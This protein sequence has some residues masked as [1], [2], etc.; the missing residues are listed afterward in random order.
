MKSIF[1]YITFFILLCSSGWSYGQ[2]VSSPKG[3][4]EINYTKGCTDLP[5]EVTLTDTFP[6]HYNRGIRFFSNTQYL[7]DTTHTYTE[8]G[9]YFVAML[10]ENPT[11][12]EYYD[13]LKVE[14][15]EPEQ[16]QFFV[17]NCGNN[18]IQVKVEHQG[19]YNQ[20]LV[21]VAG[22]EMV[23]ELT[24]TENEVVTEFTLDPALSETVVKVTG[25][26]AGEG[27]AGNCESSEK[28]VQVLSNIEA[29][30]FTSLQSHIFEAA[31]SAFISFTQQENVYHILEY[32]VNGDSE[33]RLVEEMEGGQSR[34]SDFEYFDFQNNYYCFRGKAIDRCSG[35]EIVSDLICT[36]QLEVTP[37]DHRNLVKF[38]TGNTDGLERI[39]LL[40][41]GTAIDTLA[42]TASG[43]FPDSLISCSTTYAIRLE[44]EDG[45][46]SVTK[47]L[48]LSNEGQRQLPAPINVVS[49]W[50]D[51]STVQFSLPEITGQ[52]SIRLMAYRSDGT[53][54]VNEADT[55]VISLPARGENT[56]YRFR[57]VDACGN[58]SA[59]SE[60]VC[61][62]YLQ[63]T[64]PSAEEI[65]LS[66]NEYNGYTSGVEEYVLE[67]HP[68][69]GIPYPETQG[70]FAPH[71]ISQ[72][73]FSAPKN[74]YKIIAVPQDRT[75][76]SSSSNLFSLPMKGYFPNAFSPNG[77]EINDIFKAE[78][79][80]IEGVELQIY[81]RWG[82]LVFQAA[83]NEKGWD[84]SSKGKELP[85][86][87]YIYNAV[88]TTIDGSRHSEQG[89][90]YLIRK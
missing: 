20:F 78:G 85:T 8:A 57:Y 37:E 68:E 36:A 63:S 52:D 2:N 59:L 25:E 44:Y 24:G 30:A 51:A 53:S 18:S 58:E 67:L 21:E 71:D 39:I 23:I 13:S 3:F 86:G 48:P 15:R 56:C 42:P 40:S 38:N 14:V 11:G 12:A 26:I 45:I 64:F 70:I 54:L 62:I 1:T 80:F 88:V 79:P 65:L 84:G 72:T 27:F 9:E 77:D 19:F 5:V 35:N 50:L 34:P 41:N 47:G 4:F 66:W 31:D 17:Y 43:V 89:A 7:S 81:N 29:P 87:T 74:Q 28:T 6:D 69:N 22:Q 49:K 60:T 90:V 55:T 73:A 83:D 75:L 82:A 33:F 76:P 32:T 61:A 46:S 10:I 16:P